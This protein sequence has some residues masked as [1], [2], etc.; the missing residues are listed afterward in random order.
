MQRWGWEEMVWVERQGIV[1]ALAMF[2]AVY[3]AVA[4]VCE[5]V[6]RQEG[7]RQRCRELTHRCFAFEGV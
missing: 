3:V 7:A 4:L 2:R 5:E 1:A 6:G